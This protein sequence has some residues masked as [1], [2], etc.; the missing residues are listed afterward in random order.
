MTNEAITSERITLPNGISVR[1]T[2]H[3]IGAA[4][5]QQMIPDE[6]AS[7]SVVIS[8]SM[9]AGSVNS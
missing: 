8:G 2:S 5:A 4:T 6:I 9:N 3:P 1:A 7:V